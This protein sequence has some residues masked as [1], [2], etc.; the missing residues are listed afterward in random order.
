MNW[1]RVEVTDQEGQIVAIETEM[2][3]GRDIGD[4]ERETICTAIRCLSGFIGLRPESDDAALAT[5][6]RDNAD[7]R[8]ALG[9]EQ[10]A[11]LADLHDL[12]ESL[13]TARRD[14]SSAKWRAERAEIYSSEWQGTAEQYR[15]QLATAKR[16][17]LEQAAKVC[18]RRGLV[19]RQ[20]RDSRA[21]RHDEISADLLR[22]AFEAEACAAAIRSPH[23]APDDGET[24]DGQR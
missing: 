5:A 9:P 10:V 17:A 7:L 21:D 12:R 13:A 3:A 23:P 1:F 20:R 22:V 24:Q 6:K 15:D 11:L 14:L 18:D 2:L 8:N 19:F 4:R 16:E